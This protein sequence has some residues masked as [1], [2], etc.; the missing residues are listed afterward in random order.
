VQSGD[1]DGGHLWL[2]L[3]Q[4][5]DP[6]RVRLAVEQIR[7]LAGVNADVSPTRQAIRLPFGVHKR[8]GSRETLMLQTGET[9]SFREQPGAT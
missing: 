3:D 4:A 6:A 2:P 9:F 7:A 5:A 1:H 8:T